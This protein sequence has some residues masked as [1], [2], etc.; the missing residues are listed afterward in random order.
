MK[1]EAEAVVVHR[2]E[3]AGRPLMLFIPSNAVSVI[4]S[5]L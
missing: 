5:F 4:L 1:A 2:M 3:R